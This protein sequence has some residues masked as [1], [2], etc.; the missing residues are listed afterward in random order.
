MN[1]PSK[2]RDVRNSPDFS[3]KPVGGHR[4][5]FAKNK[6]ARQKHGGLSSQLLF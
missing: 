4:R 2:L 3:D 6:R 1:A 5:F